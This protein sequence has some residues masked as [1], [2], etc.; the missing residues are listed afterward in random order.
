MELPGL[1]QWGLTK[2]RLEAHGGE[3]DGQVLGSSQILQATGKQQNKQ[4]VGEK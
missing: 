3:G 2:G 4:L 1:W